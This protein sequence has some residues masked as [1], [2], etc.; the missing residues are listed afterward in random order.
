MIRFAFLLC[1]FVS[2]VLIAQPVKIVMWHSLAGSLGEQVKQL[3]TGFNKSQSDYVVKLAYKG[4]YTDSLTSFAAAFRAKQAPDIVQVS[5]VGTATMLLP[6]GIIKP[7]D[8]LLRETG[9]TLPI[10]SFLPAVYAFYSISG[11][12]QAMPF[13]TSVPVIFYN[14]DALAKVGVRDPED[15]PH[16]WQ[17]MQ[18]L[19]VKLRQAGH[20]CA[21]TTAYPA[22]IQI[23]SFSAL[24]GLPMVDIQNGKTIYNN[25]A[26][27]QHLERLKNWQSKHYFEYGGRTSDATV[28]FTSGRCAMFSQSSGSYIALSSLV[29]FRLGVAS[30]PLDLTVSRKRHNNVIGGAALWT[31]AGKSSVVYSGIARFYQYLASVDVQ[32]RW[33]LNTGYI[34]AGLSG[35]YARLAK[36][37]NQPTLELAQ[38]DLMRES[39]NSPGLNRVP[40]NQ[41]RTINDEALEAV[42]AGIKLPKA[43]MDDAVARANFILMRFARNT[44]E[45]L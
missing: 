41:I 20:A 29:K 42:F 31:V 23:E 15:F 22:W 19:A 11:Q 43:A 33:H 4:E 45:N 44:G 3:V 24:H 9:I 16:T 26:I 28:L 7:L 8:E 32:Q 18:G 35:Y 2:T 40:Q 21:F 13:N 14:A 37:K 1:S 30:M 36:E 38:L 5:E 10:A 17:D 39:D 6:A 25:P 12:L 34:P 27:I